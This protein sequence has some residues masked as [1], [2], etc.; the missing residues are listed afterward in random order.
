MAVKTVKTE[1]TENTVKAVNTENTVKTA[2]AANQR[3]ITKFRRG[4]AIAIALV[5]AAALLMIAGIMLSSGQGN[6]L[7][8]E[9]WK[10]GQL[11]RELPLNRDAETEIQGEF[12]NHISIREGRVAV[13][14]SDCPG[15]DCVHTGWINRSGRSIVC[16][17]NRLEVR[18]V[19]GSGED[20]VDAVA[21]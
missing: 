5:V 20:E 14:E 21:R 19:N 3:D 11:V 7:K 6:D 9:I 17:P 15:E 1:N 8:A 12:T 4:D 10:D 13:T 18:V 16:L 2:K